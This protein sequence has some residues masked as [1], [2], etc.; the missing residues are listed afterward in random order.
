M[1]AIPLSSFF[2]TLHWRDNS[3]GI[4]VEPAVAHGGASCVPVSKPAPVPEWHQLLTLIE[5]GRD[6]FAPPAQNKSMTANLVITWTFIL[7]S[8]TLPVWDK[9]GD[10]INLP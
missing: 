10:P 7:T 5:H 2:R 8:P 9:P 6:L 4:R 3:S 1:R